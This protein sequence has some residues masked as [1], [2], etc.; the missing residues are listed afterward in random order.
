LNGTTSR[1]ATGLL[2]PHI[3][4]FRAAP[5]HRPAGRDVMNTD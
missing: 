1:A 5:G 3:S 4:G 2:T